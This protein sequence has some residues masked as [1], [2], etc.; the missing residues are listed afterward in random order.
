LP[1][2]T[3]SCG[4]APYWLRGRAREPDCASCLH[5]LASY[6]FPVTRDSTKDMS[7]TQVRRRAPVRPREPP[8]RAPCRGR[9]W[10][11][12]RASLGRVI[13]ARV[14]PVIGLTLPRWRSVSRTRRRMCPVLRSRARGTNML[15]MPRGRRRDMSPKAPLP[16]A[17]ARRN[18]SCDLIVGVSRPAVTL[19]RALLS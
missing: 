16:A 13:D 7:S 10:P 2:P 15:A 12:S 6:R 19:S 4:D 11:R 8:A 3:R 1:G 5:C 9:S 18:R 14:A 17:R